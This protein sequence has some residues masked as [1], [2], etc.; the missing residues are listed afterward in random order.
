MFCVTVI[1]YFNSVI[2]ECQDVS[3]VPDSLVEALAE[4]RIDFAHLKHDCRK[5]L[6]QLSQEEQ[7]ALVEF[8]PGLFPRKKDLDSF[9]SWIE[10]LIEEEISLFNIHYLKR[11]CKFDL[12]QDVR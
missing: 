3:F 6:K 12:P 10:I 7:T 8:L 9:D 4:I 11:I 5:A 2:G 1:I